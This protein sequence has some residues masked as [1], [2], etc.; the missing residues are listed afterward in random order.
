MPSKST[1]FG[2]TARF[3]CHVITIRVFINFN[4][5]MAFF[6][7]KSLTNVLVQLMK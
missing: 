1:G 2:I 5:S 6:S 7:D 4:L 3:H